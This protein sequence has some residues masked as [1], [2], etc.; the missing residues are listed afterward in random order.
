MTVVV[1][2][3]DQTPPRHTSVPMVT[4]AF[5]VN[6]V[7]GV[8]VV[9][10]D[11]ST[12]SDSVSAEDVRSGR[13]ERT[14]RTVVAVFTFVSNPSPRHTTSAAP[15]APAG[16]QFPA[17]DHETF[18]VLVPDQVFVHGASARAA[19]GSTESAPSAKSS[20]RRY[21]SDVAHFPHSFWA[22]LPW[23]LALAPSPTVVPACGLPEEAETDTGPTEPL[24]VTETGP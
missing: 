5:A 1:P 3:P 14:A 12:V 9:N 13:S 7:D 11:G 23:I 22:I 10:D 4:P 21:H 16:V 20:A 24:T 8:N 17:V 6:V 19:A 18:A 15:G 2:G